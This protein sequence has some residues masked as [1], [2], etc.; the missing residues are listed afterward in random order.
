M[1]GRDDEALGIHALRQLA[2]AFLHLARR[3]VGER[4]RRDRARFVAA[5]ADQIRDLVRDHARL[6]GARAGEHQQGAVEILARFA[7]RRIELRQHG[8]LQ[9]AGSFRARNETLGDKQWGEI[10]AAI[11]PAAVR[12]ALVHRLKS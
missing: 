7:L 3:F 9:R 2:D 1:E 12:T 11:L 6:A 4:D 10:H 5:F 8:Q